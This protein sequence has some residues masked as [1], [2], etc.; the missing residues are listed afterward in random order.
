MAPG[1]RAR[2]MAWLI[3]L[4][5]VAF[6]VGLIPYVFAADPPI[7]AGA[8]VRVSTHDFF[9]G[10]AFTASSGP[11]D[12]FQ[13]NEPS[14]A[15]DPTNPLLIAVGMNDSR[16]V[17]VSNDAWQSLAISTDGGQS[18]SFEAP[19]PGYPGDTSPEGLASPVR[20]NQAASDPWLGFDGAGR[21]FYAFI[22]F[23]R[24]PPGRPD[25]DEEATNVI[26]VARYVRT[27]YQKTVVVERGTVGLGRQEDKEALAVDP[28]NGNVYVCWARFTGF[29]SH[30]KVARS[31]DHGDSYQISDL[32][33]VRNMQG[34][35]LTT[36]PNG[37]VYVA[38]RT[39]DFNPR[40]TNP[41]DSFIYLARSTDDGAT[42]GR[43]VQVAR[44]VDYSQLASRTPPIFRTSA[45][46]FLAA[47]INGVY[48]GWQQK[49]GTNG[50]DIAVTRSTDNGATWDPP[51]RPRSPANHHQIMPF[52]AAAGGKLSV[53]WYDSRNEPTF[54]PDGPITAGMDVFYSQA[55]TAAASLVFGPEIRVTSQTFNPLTYGSIKA[56]TPFIGDYISM[57]A[58]P[59][60][61]F[62]VWTDN[63]DVNA[64]KNAQEDDDVSTDPPSLINARSRD[65][66]IYFQ[67]VVK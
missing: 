10:D 52:L 22:A 50:A 14:I 65:S 40:N 47:D 44:F 2:G 61:A 60:D 6:T 58:T 17:P 12:V 46:A 29:Q 67:R 66:N 4:A 49:N 35:N 5:I 25:F 57:A 7:L 8:N 33:P 41:Q 55:D 26:A 11:P 27:Q 1:S 62:I 18:F 21:L 42:F 37:D 56:I 30:L 28:S 9:P 16:T 24:Q 15:L 34:C 64:E 31:T 32:G 39:F 51:V 53:A 20:G 38:W 59:S 43:P 48:V 13:Q 19:V 54:N 23:Q 45:D 63:R 3:G 36:A